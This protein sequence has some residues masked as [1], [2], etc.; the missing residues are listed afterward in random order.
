[1]TCQGGKLTS[2][3]KSFKQGDMKVVAVKMDEK[4]VSALSKQAKKEFTSVSSIVKKA[5]DKYLKEQ[6]VNWEQEKPEKK[7]KR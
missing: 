4:M 3:G 5:V 7:P 2:G 6:G 1:M